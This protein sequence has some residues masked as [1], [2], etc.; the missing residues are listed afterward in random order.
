MDDNSFKYVH[1]FSLG[2]FCGT[3]TILGK[4]G[5]RA[6]SGPFDWYLSNY[7]G[8][9]KQIGNNFADFMNK[10]NLKVDE[11]NNKAFYDT[12]YDFY[13]NHD[14]ITD[15]DTE[16]DDIKKRYYRRANNFINCIAEPSVFF[17]TIR[18]RDE[19]EYINRNWKYADDLLKSFNSKNRIIYVTNAELVG[20]TQE[21][22][23]YRL[24]IKCWIRKTYEMRH[25]FDTNPDLIRLCSGL[26]D[27][28]EIEANKEFD[29]SKNTQKAV[30]GY[31]NKCVKE[32]IDNIEDCI[33][34]KLGA[35]KKEGIYLWG[36]GGFGIPLAEYLRDKGVSILGIIDNYHCGEKITGF[37]V[38]SFGN[39]P[40]NSKAFITISK[41]DTNI[42]ILKQIEES[43]KNVHAVCYKDLYEQGMDI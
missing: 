20:L 30:A 5:L 26:I 32:N 10:D 3:A 41:L 34:K 13:C 21:V 18:D 2:W 4:M 36:A 42:E 22:E 14:I 12:K 27:E 38:V 16:F 1:C 8:V 35:S 17:R 7:S 23:S 43:G 9:L 29:F 6:R 31:V 40:E 33:L 28:K 11:D 19:V 25:L 15:F 39:V 37:D 24:S